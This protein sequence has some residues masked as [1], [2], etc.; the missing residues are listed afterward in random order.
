MRIVYDQI[1][2]ADS[3][4]TTGSPFVCPRCYLASPMGFTEA[5]Q[6]YYRD[7][8]VPALSQ[9]VEVVDPWPLADRTA[10]ATAVDDQRARYM[11][12]G[13][14]NAVAIESC[15]LL[16]AD[17][18]GQE[19]DSGT[20]AEIGY[21]AGHGLLC[22]GLRS[23]LRQAGEAALRVNAQVEFFIHASGGQIVSSLVDLVFLLE[24][25]NGTAGRPAMPAP[26]T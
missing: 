22:L 14:N 25:L 11:A 15:S 20:A 3:N 12:I 17:L 1:V 4:D 6:R 10:I 21:A 13:R 26:P 8:Y 5:G 24:K 2:L 7:V 16:I 9:H 18:D 19:V 23:D